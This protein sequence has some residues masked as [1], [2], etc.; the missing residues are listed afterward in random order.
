[1]R[2]RG[3][4]FLPERRPSPPKRCLSE[5]PAFWFAQARIL[6]LNSPV[7]NGL[8]I[9]TL[10]LSS[11]RLTPA[12]EN[13]AAVAGSGRTIRNAAHNH[14]PSSVDAVVPYVFPSQ[15]GLC[16]TQSYRWYQR[17]RLQGAQ[18][19]FWLSGYRLACQNLR[20]EERQT[21][22]NRHLCLLSNLG[23]RRAIGG[24]HFQLVVGG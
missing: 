6:A 23:T 22:R 13:V 7:L 11:S 2:N 9:Q 14:A 4:A 18:C 21:F 17:E 16:P 3:K 1:M 20:N 19:E 8:D 12:V 10:R 15:H 5:G 24:N